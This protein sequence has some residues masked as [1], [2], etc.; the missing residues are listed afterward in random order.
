MLRSPSQ[1]HPLNSTPESIAQAKKWRS[2][3][4]A[5]CH[6]KDGDRKGETAEDRKL[7]IADFSDSATLK[8]HTDGEIFCIIKN[9]HEEMPPEG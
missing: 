3:D 1:P 8:D 4:C 2:L 9:G 6:G 5:M 7:A